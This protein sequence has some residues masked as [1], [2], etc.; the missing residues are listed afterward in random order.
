MIDRAPG[1]V[2]LAPAHLGRAD[3]AV[4]AQETG[5]LHPRTVELI[6]QVA[7]RV[8]QG[9]IDAWFDLSRR[10]AAGRRGRR[11]RQGHQDTLD[12]WFDSGV[13]HSCVLLPRDLQWPGRPLPGRLRPASRL[14]PVLAADLGIGRCN[15]VAPYKAGADPRLHGGRAGAQDVQVAGQR[16]RAAGHHEQPRR[17]HPAP[18]GRRDRLPRRDVRVEEI[19]K[20]VA[21]AYRRIRN[22]ARFLLANLNGFDPARTVVANEDMLALDRWIVDRAIRY[23]RT[24]VRPTNYE[25]HQIYHKLH[26]FCATGSRRLLPRHHQGPPVHHPDRLAG[27]PLGA[28]GAAHLVEALVR[29]IAP[30]LSFTADDI[31]KYIPG[32][33]GES[34]FLE[35]WYQLP[36]AEIKIGTEKLGF[37]ESG[38]GVGEPLD[39]DQ[40]WEQIIEA[41]MAVSKELEKLRVSGAIGSSLDA[42]VDLYCGDKLHTYLAGL[43]DELRFVLITS[44]ARVHTAGD[45]PA[46]AVEAAAGG[47]P[48]WIKV[49]ASSH[50]KC[51]RCWHHRAD[52]G[53][54]AEHPELCGRCIENV[55]GPGEER[56]YA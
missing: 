44:Y 21:D 31:W 37:D 6:E 27:A 54:D 34:V 29:W 32:A 52:V 42:E 7:Q 35:E 30:I 38:R 56:R 41:R 40:I 8:E 24:Y 18:V 4:R 19:L 14:V 5:E 1:L 47:E 36:T 39:W 2:H 13:T 55:A 33:R 17:R 43:G 48:F 50:P 12:V 53:N 16:D 25:F 22:T 45:R 46:D 9:G 51:V 23:S 28:D 3:R 20:R 11:L 10:G 49:R 15:G 26:N